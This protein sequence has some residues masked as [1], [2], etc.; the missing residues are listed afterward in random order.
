MLK[1]VQKLLDRSP[2]GALSMGLGDIGGK[3]GKP[4]AGNGSYGSGKKGGSAAAAADGDE[5][6]V[7]D[8]KFPVVVIGA[9]ALN[10]EKALKTAA[11]FQRRGD[12]VVRIYTNTVSGVDTY[13]IDGAEEG[14]EKEDGADSDFDMSG[15]GGLERGRTTVVKQR[16]RK[17]STLEV[18]IRLKT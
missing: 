7:G 11:V 16:S 15:A 14:D 2:G 17:A 9:G 4:K 13:E 18:A 1:R 3:A 5:V 8:D 6:Q 12:C 10:I